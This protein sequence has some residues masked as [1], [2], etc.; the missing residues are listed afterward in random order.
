MPSVERIK[1]DKLISEEIL[2]AGLLPGT[3]RGKTPAFKVTAPTGAKICHIHVAGWDVAE[4]PLM[5]ENILKM[6]EA[7]RESHTRNVVLLV[8]RPAINNKLAGR[9]IAQLER[10]VV[11]AIGTYVRAYFIGNP[12]TQETDSRAVI[13]KMLASTK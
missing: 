10:E 5:K 8:D 13:R 1:A 3:N 2:N 4:N 7:F 9:N 11:S 12:C 6:R